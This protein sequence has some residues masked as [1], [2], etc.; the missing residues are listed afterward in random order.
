M[1]QK[2]YVLG[3]WVVGMYPRLENLQFDTHCSQIW[4]CPG[5]SDPLNFFGEYQNLLTGCIPPT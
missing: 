3:M 4:G 1:F 2:R 5:L